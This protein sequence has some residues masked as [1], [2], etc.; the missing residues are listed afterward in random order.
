MA[1]SNKGAVYLFTPEFSRKCGERVG[2][3]PPG[4]PLGNTILAQ[5]PSHTASF[6]QFNLAHL[7][8]KVCITF[9]SQEVRPCHRPGDKQLFNRLSLADPDSVA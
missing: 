9:H 7:V 6:K 1:A 3:S 8:C 2:L 5:K 4:L